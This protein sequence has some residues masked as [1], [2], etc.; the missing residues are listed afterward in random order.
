MAVGQYGG[1]SQSLGDVF[2][3]EA[4]VVGEDFFGAV[5]SGDLVDYEANGDAHSA[6]A[7]FS[8]HDAWCVGD[9]VQLVHD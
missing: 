2:F 5:A 4:T 8:A 3:F 9:A 1:V 7:G 6:D